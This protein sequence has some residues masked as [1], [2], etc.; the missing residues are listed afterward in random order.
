MTLILE[1]AMNG[2]KIVCSVPLYQATY[3]LR[4]LQI[5]D[6]VVLANGFFGPVTA[7][8]GDQIEIA[9]INEIPDDGYPAK[10]EDIIW[11]APD[12]MRVKVEFLPYH[13]PQQR[14]YSIEELVELLVHDETA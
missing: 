2:Q 1:T 11:I 4:E 5:G 13:E 10:R 7:K 12:T 3:P 8:E 9:P 6:F 14:E